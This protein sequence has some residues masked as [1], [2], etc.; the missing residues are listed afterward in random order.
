MHPD[1]EA[2]QQEISDARH[3]GLDM[4]DSLTA[5]QINWRFAPG[6]WSIAECI[7]H[8]SVTNELYVAAT[9]H[10]LDSAPASRASD[11]PV[12]YRWLESFLL[13]QLEPPVKLRFKAPSAF[14]PASDLRPEMLRQKWEA[15]HN[16]IAQLI[17]RADGVAF[18]KV[19]V[20]SPGSRFLKLHVGMVFHVIAAHD[21]RH[22]WQSDQLK[23]KPGFPEAIRGAASQL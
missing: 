15:S 10:A 22:L 14:Q 23:A 6:S 7:E 2:V 19:K 3:R 21:R 12:R 18:D 16:G 11:G 8:M 20:Q 1:L 5:E 4:I 17:R 13:R 9:Q